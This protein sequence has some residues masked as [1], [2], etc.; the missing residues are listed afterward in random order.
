VPEAMTIPLLF[1]QNG[2]YVSGAGK[3]THGSSVRP[4]DWHDF[5]PVQDQNEGGEDV[6]NDIAGRA[7]RK[8]DTVVGKFSWHVVPN[9]NESAL[10]D[11]RI[12]SYIVERLKKKQ[13][14]PFFLA[15]GIHRPHVPWNVPQKYFD[16]YPLN[17][18]K[19]P[20]INPSDL[21]D[22]GPVGKRMAHPELDAEIRGQP[23]G[24]E[25]AIQAYL[26]AVSFC[27]AQ[28]G[29]LLDALDQSPNRDNTIIVFWGDHG[30]H[31]GEKQHWAK[32]VLW[33]EASRAP[34][35]WVVPG[36]TK[37]GGVCNRTVDFLSIFPTLCDLAGLPT[38]AQCKNPSIRALLADPK[39]VWDRPAL[40]TFQKGNHAVRDERWRYIRYADGEEELYDHNADPLEWTNIAG[41]PEFASVK[42][43]LAKW[44]PTENAD[45]KGRSEPGVAR[46]KGKKKA[47]GG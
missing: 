9:A 32:A 35:L 45:D 1:K 17:Q 34:L 5:G 42:A 24:P 2:Y 25:K 16:L 19:Q 4:S 20:Q 33:E 12:T 13:D 14:Q 43:S 30:W 18:I 21:D 31:H 3:I 27:D 23:Q 38:P 6:G 47:K 26:A 36:V 8:E 29:R 44:L 39:A 28:I 7:P 10:V 46:K 41:K 40:T 15:C 37:P 11:Y 22:I